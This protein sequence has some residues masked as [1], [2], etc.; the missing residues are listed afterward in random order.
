MAPSIRCATARIGMCS[1][2]YVP[3]KDYVV[4]DIHCH[5][6]PEVDDGPKSWDTAV[7][8]CRMAAADGITHSVATPH[9]ND[10]YV[11]DRG[12]LSG[13][14]DQLR[15]KLQEESGGELGEKPGPA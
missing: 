11:Y 9:A 12:Y 6:L 7:E 10:R 3:S 2:Q 15:E 4:I 14:L 13:L 8:M 1:N 5:L